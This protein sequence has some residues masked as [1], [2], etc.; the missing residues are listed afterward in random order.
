V[1]SALPGLGILV[2]AAVARAEPPVAVLD[3]LLGSERTTVAL[4]QLAASETLAPGEEFRMLELGRDPHSSHH[5][6]WIRDRE[7]PHRHDRHDLLVVILRGH[8]AMQLGSEAREVGEGSVLY[9]PRGTIHAFR[10]ASDAPA[11]AY[12][13]YLPAFDGSDRVVEP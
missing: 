3:A 6:V 11:A 9:V 1:R 13:V 10:N 4:S 5:L 12:A 2:L 8:G 7:V